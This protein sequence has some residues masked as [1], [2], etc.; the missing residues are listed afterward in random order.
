MNGHSE[1]PHLLEPLQVAHLTLKNRVLMGSMHIGLEEERDYGRMA[2]YFAARASVGLIVTGGIAPNR[3]GWGKPFAAKLAGP[4]EVKRHRQVTDAVHAA[5]GHIAMQILHTGRYAY[6]PFSVAPSRIKSPITPFTPRAL[7]TSG[8]EGQIEDFVRCGVL[9]KEAGYDGVE[10]MGSEGYFIN[11]FI[12][13]RTNKRTDEWGGPYENRIRFPIEIVRRLRE[14]VGPD[15]I[16]VFRLSMLDLVPEGSTWEEVVILA[17]ALEAAGVSIINT[18][19]G[20]H[21]ARV[22]TIATMVPR[23]AFTWVTRK[24]KAEVGVP[25]VTS[26]RINT[27]ETG[28][29]V[30]SRGDADMVSLARPLLADPDF[31][32]KAVEGRADRINTC[33]ACNQA[34]LDHVFQNKRCSCLVNPLACHETERT[35]KPASQPRRVAVVGGGP[36]G[37]SAAS[38]AAERGH[39]V[40]LF[41]AT[42]ELGGQF[43]LAQ[44]VPGK[45]EFAETLR[46]FRNRLDDAGVEVRLGTRATEGDLGDFDVVVVATGVSPRKPSLPGIERP[47]VL[48]YVDVFEGAPVGKS[49]AIIG[50]GGIGF[51]VAEFL[52]HTHTEGPA[53]EAFLAEWGIDHDHV[54]RGGLR[55]VQQPPPPRKVVMMQRKKGKLGAG[56][57]KT[58]GW[59]HRTQLGKRGVEMLDAVVY[60]RIDD[61]GVHI[62][63]GGQKRV[64]EVDNV[65]VCAGQ[66]KAGGLATLAEL[67][68]EVHTIGGARMAGELDAKR[69][70]REG[71]EI[72]GRI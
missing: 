68:V 29:E 24:L 61:A 23:A 33:I 26:N 36:A 9:A 27:P 15:F 3:A 5:G 53:L 41:E 48:S 65:V 31:V 71:A 50:A 59:I 70:I 43:R 19:I 1:Y 4:G 37:L 34:C 30:L 14:A 49:V 28:E 10:V 6:H 22:P 2:A 40:V 11:E 64:L 20:W 42:A 51:D 55:P 60:D 52:T 16:I 12:V 67:D 21:E 46:Y 66:V 47:E 45:E 39:D 58:T 18:G 62:S 44:S 35:P 7:S 69:A 8:V 32:N 38:V 13:T 17:K 56:L 72:A 25:L 63:V 54:E 57:G